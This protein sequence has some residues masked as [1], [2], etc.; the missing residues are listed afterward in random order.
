MRNHPV[1][2][3]RLLALVACFF[4][5]ISSDFPP[6]ADAQRTDLLPTIGEQ[7]AVQNT[8]ISEINIHLAAT[9]ERVSKQWTQS[10]ANAS[11]I[12]VIQGNTDQNKWWLG[13]IFAMVSGSIVFQ[14]RKQK[15]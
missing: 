10:N 14:V 13:V 2:V 15:V 12:A 4:F 3:C 6:P 1:Y 7:I 11:A 8:E 9:D 5:F